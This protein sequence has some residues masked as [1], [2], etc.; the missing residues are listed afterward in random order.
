MS[1][2][3]VSRHPHHRCRHGPPGVHQGRRRHPHPACPSTQVARRLGI[4]RST[5]YRALPLIAVQTSADARAADFG[6]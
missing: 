4:D 3:A 1:G 6:N 5:L 2:E